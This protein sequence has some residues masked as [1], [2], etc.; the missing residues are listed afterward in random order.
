VLHAI[1]AA[2]R[3]YEPEGPRLIHAARSV[4]AAAHGFATLQA[5]GGFQVAEDVEESYGI[6]IDMIIDGVARFS[7]TLHRQTR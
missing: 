6:L 3:E 7:T 2:L 5:G 1:I 4:R